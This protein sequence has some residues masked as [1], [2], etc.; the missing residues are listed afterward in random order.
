MSYV[1]PFQSL[2]SAKLEAAKAVQTIHS[3]NINVTKRE[4]F[5]LNI[6]QSFIARGEFPMSGEDNL[7]YA[8]EI[9]DN[10]LKRLEETK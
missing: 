5:A 8:I 10:L 1:D 7:D 2:N 4:Y 3:I 9:A 6:L